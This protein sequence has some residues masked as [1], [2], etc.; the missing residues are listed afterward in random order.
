MKRLIPFTALA[1]CGISTAFGYIGRT[2]TTTGTPPQTVQI[3]QPASANISYFLNNLVVAGAVS[4][5]SGKTVFTAGSNPAVAVERAMATWNSVGSA[6]IH[7]N[8]LQ[9]TT[10]GYSPSDCQNTISMAGS[11]SD[12]SE[13]T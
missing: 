8:G 2:F 5:L 9:S 13:P 3:L 4:S 11:A 7:F 12:L 10:A 1:L 6:N